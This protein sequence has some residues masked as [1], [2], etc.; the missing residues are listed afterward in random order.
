MKWINLLWSI[1]LLGLLSLILAYLSSRSSDTIVG[2]A[3]G[4]AL[5]AW[6]VICIISPI[7][8]ILR[9]LRV[10]RSSSS[11]IYILTGTASIAI[12]FLGLYFMGPG[13]YFR[14]KLAILVI[15]SLNLLIGLFIYGDAFVKT[16]PGL[17]KR[18][19]P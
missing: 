3:F 1:V 6:I 13:D 19:E 14:N 9:L 16:I 8:L 2:P 7:I 11:F 4:Y 12:G 17:Q 18:K 10:I 5:I 15:F